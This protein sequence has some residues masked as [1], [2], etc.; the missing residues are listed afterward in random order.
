MKKAGGT[1]IVQSP[2]SAGFAAM[3]LSIP[4]TLVDITAAPEAMGRIILDIVGASEMP[5]DGTDRTMLRTLLA[6][7]RERSG[8]DFS[9]YK[10]PTI[11]RR[12]SRL[13][14]ASGVS[15]IAEY[16]PFLQRNPE[17]YQRLVNSFLIK[18][19][20]FFR[21][22]ALFEAL[23]DNILPKLMTEAR[24][25]NRELRIWSAGS[26]TGEEA[27][28]L[29]ILCAELMRD[30]ES[31]IGVRIFATDVDEL[32]VSFARR[33][34]YSSD[35]LRH[36]PESLVARYFS[37]HDDRYE[38]SKQI[39]NMTV[40]GQHDLG[41]RAPFPR[42]DLVLCRNVLIYFTKE[43]QARA[44][45]LF[46]FAL[47][48]GGYLVL[49]KAESTTSVPRFFKVSQLSTEDLRTRGRARL[50]AA[51]AA[52]GHGAI[53]ALANVPR[54]LRKATAPDAQCKRNG[55]STVTRRRRRIHGRVRHR[56]RG[57]RSELR[58]RRD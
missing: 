25:Q 11:M 7:L 42:I 31:S 29:A 14:V 54:E 48:D 23:R 45:Q 16:L 46:A 21:D 53:S 41:Q 32:A 57:G 37:K 55:A 13:M 36:V 24:E 27:Y 19:T 2:E 1:V 9:Q 43:L 50:A 33:G 35:S 8:I 44:L 52:Q 6:Q 51:D 3:P 28:S 56:R 18:V 17:G 22:A 5:P 15:S 10:T 38:V 12:L 58:Y 20:E 47:R 34:V 30:Q 4:P 39:R 49:G 26:S 40:F